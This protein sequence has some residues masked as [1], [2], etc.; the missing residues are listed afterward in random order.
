MYLLSKY[1]TKKSQKNKEDIKEE[2]DESLV[3]DETDNIEIEEKARMVEKPEDATKVVQKFKEISSSI[4]KHIIW[5]AFHQG[6][7]F[8]MFKQGQ[9]FSNIIRK[10]GVS[11]LTILF[12][13]VFAKRINEYPK[14][15]K[16]IEK[17][18]LLIWKSGKFVKKILANINKEK[19]LF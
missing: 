4:K 10:F 15:E 16:H 8:E 18:T 6:M 5:L 12:K 17:N 11:R 1:T 19:C 2:I 13:I 7:I 3:N 9:K 14:K